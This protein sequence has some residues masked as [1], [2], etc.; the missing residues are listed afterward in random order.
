[1]LRMVG[2]Y[3]VPSL[4]LFSFGFDFFASTNKRSTDRYI[5]FVLL[6]PS[7]ECLARKR[8]KKIQKVQEQEWKMENKM[9]KLSVCGW[10][11]RV[12]YVFNGLRNARSKEFQPTKR[13]AM[14]CTLHELQSA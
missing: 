12:G 4:Y 2:L 6:L 3:L 9:N 11:S 10:D 5:F 14:R 13:M 7:E 1:M 8:K